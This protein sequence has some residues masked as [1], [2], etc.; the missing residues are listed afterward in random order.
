MGLSQYRQI[1]AK[2]SA[3]GDAD[4]D[5]HTGDWC[6]ISGT[7]AHTAGVAA[8]I[9]AGNRLI[10]LSSTCWSLVVTKPPVVTR[11]KPNEGVVT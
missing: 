9:Q 7:E 3:K 1:F 10:V 2:L 11:A 5:A 6:N 8:G 4:A